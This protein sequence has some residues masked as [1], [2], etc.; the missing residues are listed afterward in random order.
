VKST[1][2]VLAGVPALVR[3]AGPA[4][5]AAER[6]TVLYYHGFG[7]DKERC[8]PYLTALAEAGFLAVSLDAGGHGDRRLADFGTIVNDE[9][10]D[11]DF[12]ATEAD[13]T[14]CRAPTAA[15]GS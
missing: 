9:R 8:E 5:A 7:G 4:Q 15:G 13:V 1:G 2:A 10:W 3:S 11:A 12:E 14:E 6:G